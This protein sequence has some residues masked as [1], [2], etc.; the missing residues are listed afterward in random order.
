MDGN[1][2][3]AWFKHVAVIDVTS[4]PGTIEAIL[5]CDPGCHGVQW[6]A[7]AESDG[8]LAYVTSKFSNALIVIDPEADGGPAEVGRVILADRDADIDN[9]VIGYDGMGGQGVLAI[10]NVY[11]G[12]IQETVSE[13]SSEFLDDLS[14][15]QKTPPAVE[16]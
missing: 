16:P 9:P 10:P 2:S 15:I 1:S 5:P 7:K 14:V 4:T 13:G 8:Y 11:G 6:G 12:W 3:Y